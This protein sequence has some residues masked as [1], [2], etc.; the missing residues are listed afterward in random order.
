MNV[1]IVDFNKV[2]LSDIQNIVDAYNVICE[3]PLLVL[4]HDVTYIQD[5]PIKQL[6]QIR[7]FINKEL[8]RKSK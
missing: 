3:E 8:E 5:M 7:D 1:M 6:V 2:S 4:P